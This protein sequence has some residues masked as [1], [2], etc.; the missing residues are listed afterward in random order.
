MRGSPKGY[1]ST[2]EAVSEDYN[3]EIILAPSIRLSHPMKGRISEAKD[4][5]EL[6]LEDYE[7]TIFYDRLAFIIEIPSIRDVISG[8]TLSLTVGGVRSYSDNLYSRRGIEE[9]FK[10]FVG[11]KNQVCTNLCVWTDGLMNDLKVNNTAQL[12][13][14]IKGLLYNYN[15]QFHLE[16]MKQLSHFELS[17]K[18]FA[19]LIGRCRIYN[20]LPRKVKQGINPLAITD[21]QVGILVKDY[22]SDRDFQCNPDGSINLW[23]LY[24][25]FTGANKSSYI[26]NFLDRSV[27]AYHFVESIRFALQN[28][29]FSWYLS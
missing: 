23:R 1:D 20:H 2:V 12:K 8:N 29:S 11:F 19:N 9:S 10:V 4:K 5:S 25:L 24:N 18:Q 16:Q 15:S 26:D 13:A 21:T 6:E 17:E 14:C 3:G 27:N 28:Q 22:Y 7:K